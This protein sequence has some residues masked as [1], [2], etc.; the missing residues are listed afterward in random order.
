L[1][2][3]E[4][5]RGIKIASDLRSPITTISRR[6]PAAIIFLIGAILGAKDR[7]AATLG[8][9]EK[10]NWENRLAKSRLRHRRRGMP[11]H[12]LLFTSTTRFLR[13]SEIL[14]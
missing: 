8:V 1:V 2:S 13:V 4:L 11:S 9:V 12:V 14:E 5:A 3:T 6:S 10:S 7:K